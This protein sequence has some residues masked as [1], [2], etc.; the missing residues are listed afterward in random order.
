MFIT[1][2]AGHCQQRYIAQQ[3]MPR[4][5]WQLSPAQGIVTASLEQ[6]PVPGSII[7]GRHFSN[8]VVSKNR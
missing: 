6:E 8:Q 4:S 2:V 3:H 5:A 1:A 7:S